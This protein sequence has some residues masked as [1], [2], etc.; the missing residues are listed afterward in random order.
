[1]ERY[2]NKG[3]KSLRYGYTTGSCATAAAKGAAM[4]L[5]SGREIHSIMLDTPRGWELA[6]PVHPVEIREDRATCYVIK[7]AGDDPDVTHGM[8]IYG[9]VKLSNTEGI[10]ISG[11]TG[12]GIVTKEGLQIPVGD[13]AI[14]PTPR[15]TI[16]EA[17][18]QVLPHQGVEVMIYAPEG[19]AIAKKTFNANLGILGGISIIGTSGIVEPM[20]ED[21]LL[22][23]LKVELGVKK[24]YYEDGLVYVFGNYGRDYALEL[25]IMDAYIQKMSN[26]VAYMMRQAEELSFKKVLLVGHVG[27]MV[28]VAT[29]RENTHSKYGDGRMASIGHCARVCGV[30]ES[31]INQIL[32][33]NTTD[34]AVAILEKNNKAKA[35]FGYMAGLCQQVLETMAAKQV[36]VGCIIFST[37]HGQLGASINAWELLE[38]FTMDNRNKE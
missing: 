15:R 19:E 28:K 21:A 30:G 17:I 6:I 35:V 26:Y 5:L 11:G 32:D 33:C 10:S 22:D 27:K 36:Q 18:R 4:M 2:I 8:R 1:M 3:G 24:A 16:K 31:I 20:S 7:D 29:G 14:N 13:H 34:E 38:G 9:Q 23:T 12:I 25:G 37:I